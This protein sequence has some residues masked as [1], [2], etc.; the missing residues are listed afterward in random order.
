MSL[1]IALVQ[2]MPEATTEKN[3]EK[4]LQACEQAKQ[5]GA[6]LILFPEMW[7]IGYR[8]EA[9]LSDNAIDQNSF[10]LQEFCRQAK[11]LSLAI[12]ITYLGKGQKKPTNSLA[13]IDAGGTVILEY[14]KVHICCFGDG[15]D[16]N[17]ECNLEAGKSFKVAQLSFA[18]GSISVG[19]MICFDRE[20]PESARSLMLQGAELILVPNACALATCNVLGDVRLQQVRSRAFENMCAVAVANYPAPLHDGNSCVVGPAGNILA[21]LP[22]EAKNEVR[23]LRP[24]SAIIF[25]VKQFFMHNAT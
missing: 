17:L 2:L 18:G 5:R 3:L 23:A 15:P 10:F 21:C 19:A 7:H 22:A 16:D 6:D 20:F 24:G 13:L 1:K 11:K 25:K 12:A 14:A 4:G 9:F 8:K